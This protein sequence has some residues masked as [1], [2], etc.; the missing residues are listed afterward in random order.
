LRQSVKLVRRAG[1]ILAMLLASAGAGRG[2]DDAGAMEFLLKNAPP[3]N[4]PRLFPSPPA[5]RYFTPTPIET[6]RVKRRTNAP[7]DDGQAPSR[8]IRAGSAAAR[9]A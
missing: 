8:P 3:I 6:Y 2:A 5:V 9:F 4:A 1:T 7:V